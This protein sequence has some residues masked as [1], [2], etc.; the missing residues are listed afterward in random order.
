MGETTSDFLVHRLGPPPAVLIG[1]AA[2]SAALWLQLRAGRYVAWIYWLAVA[3]VG[4][5]GT[6]AADVLHVGLG[7]PYVVS[8]TFYAIVLTAVFMTWQRSE[9]T[10][11]IHSIL[12]RRRELFYWA[13]VLATFALGTAAGDMTA[14]TLG[15][16][17]LGSG[18]MFAVLIAVPAVA[19]RRFGMNAVLAFWFAYIVTRPLGAS[20]ADW[21]AVPNSRGGL[22]F[23]YGPVSVVLAVLIVAFVAY[24]ASS[25]IDVVTAGSSVPRGRGRDR[26]RR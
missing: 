11:S 25:R 18:V 17:Y 8:T 6:M 1:L 24:L 3:M 26:S 23:G 14:R 12:T 2:F 22:G 7:I 4:V 21:M 5:F 15:L 10:L 13:A 16:G 9:L 20:F 19:C